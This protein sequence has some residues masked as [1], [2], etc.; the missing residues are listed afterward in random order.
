MHSKSHHKNIKREIKK[1]IFE[2]HIT[3]KGL[4]PLI[5]SSYKSIGKENNLRKMGIK[6]EKVHRK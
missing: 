4:I 5:K 3:D 2:T 1:K 6:Q